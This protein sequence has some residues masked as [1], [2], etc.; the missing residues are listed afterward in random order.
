MCSSC[1]HL[2]KF[3][4]A[5]RFTNFSYIHF[6]RDSG[7]VY[8]RYVYLSKVGGDSD[9]LAVHDIK[10]DNWHFTE[11]LKV[12]I[13]GNYISESFSSTPSSPS[14]FKRYFLQKTIKLSCM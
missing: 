8:D 2:S 1:N 4:R 10:S 14:S 11:Y 6:S 3:N 13:I 12:V 7:V 5:L 9:R